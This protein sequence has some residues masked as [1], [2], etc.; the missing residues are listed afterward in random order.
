MPILLASTFVRCWSDWMNPDRF[1]MKVWTFR[2]SSVLDGC[3]G[4]G[5]EFAAGVV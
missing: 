1:R 5:V 2:G 3:V 4:T